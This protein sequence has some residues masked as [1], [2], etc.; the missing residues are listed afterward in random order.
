MNTK[1]AKQCH[2]MMRASDGKLYDI[3]LY[4]NGK[5][6]H[7][8][9][10]HSHSHFE[11]AFLQS[12]TLLNQTENGTHKLNKGDIMIMRPECEHQIVMDEDN[13][14]LLFNIEINYDFLKNTVNSIEG[15]NVDEIIV[16][17]IYYLPCTN[18]EIIQINDLLTIA[19]SAKNDFKKTQFTLKL[20]VLFM[21]TKLY[22]Y[23]TN[24]NQDKNSNAI[25]VNKLLNELRNPDN[26]T[27]NTNLI[28]KKY[29]YSQEHVIRLFKKSGLSSPN[30]IFMENKMN[31]ACNLLCNSDM[32]IISIAELCGIFTQNHFD[33]T[34]KKHYGI[35]PSNYRKKFS[36]NN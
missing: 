33:C 3:N 24:Y 14:Y 32:K 1:K 8:V 17:P 29:N 26:F 23:Q 7:F 27:L 16:N 6:N 35:S 25:I 11:F 18:Q 20:L 19:A 21:T 30:K 4:I 9:R 5:S 28:F 36:N 31:Y 22:V 13:D 10:K 15:V 12:G 34:F 2:D